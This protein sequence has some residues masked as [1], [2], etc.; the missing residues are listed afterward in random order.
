MLQKAVDKA[1]QAGQ[2]IRFFRSS[3][4]DLKDKSPGKY[5]LILSPGNSFSHLESIPMLNNSL[6]GIKNSLE[7]EGIFAFDIRNWEKTF[8]SKNLTPQE[9]EAGS[10][11][12]KMRVKYSWDITGWNKSCKMIVETL[13]I[14]SSVYKKYIFD[15]FPVGYDQLERSLL[16]AGFTDVERK[17]YPDDNYYFV[18]AR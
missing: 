9:F 6:L 12:R 5:S 10:R 17:F 4:E 14:K 1:R 15:F 13:H 16:K 8:S 11:G 7:K 18:V 2:G 3:W